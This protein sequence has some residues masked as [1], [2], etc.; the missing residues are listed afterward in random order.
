MTTHI[1]TN[2]ADL[3]RLFTLLNHRDLPITVN[4]KNGKDRSANQ[5]RLMHMWMHE[6]EQQG[7]QTAEEY[8]GYCKLH[9]GVPILRNE[10]EEFREAYDEVIRP[11]PYELKLKAMMVPLDFP[12][13][14]LMKTGQMKRYLDD[15]YNHFTGLGMRL[16]QPD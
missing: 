13:S 4:V 3:A 15:I 1:I 7:D 2:K 12:C 5:N 14:R 16:T 6:A 11:L 8:R 9:F 10:N